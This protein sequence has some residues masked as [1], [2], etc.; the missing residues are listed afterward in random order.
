MK[1]LPTESQHTLKE[2]LNKYTK[3][4]ETTEGIIILGFPIG[5]NEFINKALSKVYTKVK[6]TIISLKIIWM[7]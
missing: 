6:E 4:K 7:T 2:C 3:G 1:H 5:S